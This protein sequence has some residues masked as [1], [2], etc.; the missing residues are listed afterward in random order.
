LWQ[1]EQVDEARQIFAQMLELNPN[2]N[3][4]ARF[5]LHDLE[6]GLSWEEAAAE[7]EEEI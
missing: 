4:G 7:E 5:L 2:D 3:Q 6:E 1:L